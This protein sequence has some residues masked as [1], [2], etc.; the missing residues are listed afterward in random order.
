MPWKTVTNPNELILD[1]A[2]DVTSQLA[3]ETNSKSGQ[4]HTT[5]S[6]DGK[7]VKRVIPEVTIYTTKVRHYVYTSHLAFQ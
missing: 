4:R 1:F 6:L 7:T 5:E 3:D 2:T